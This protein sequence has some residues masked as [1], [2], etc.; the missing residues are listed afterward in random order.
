MIKM[1]SVPVPSK[2]PLILSRQ[3][4]TRL[5]DG[6]GN[7]KYRNVTGSGLTSHIMLNVRPDPMQLP[8]ELKHWVK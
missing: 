2:L 4:V 5:I 6:A 1:S 7:P 8:N 3:E